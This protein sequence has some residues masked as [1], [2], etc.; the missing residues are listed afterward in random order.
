LT[1]TAIRETTL[2]D[3]VARRLVHLQW[4]ELMVRYREA[5]PEDEGDSIP[6]GDF[7]PPAGT[8]LVLE[9]DGEPVGC[10]GV[11]PC[12]EDVPG[13]G[14]IKR[15][16]VVE[17]CRGRGLSRVLLAALED[18]AA[19]LGYARIWLE[20]GTA[21]PEALAL[22]ASA[23]YAPIAPYGEYRDAPDVRCFQKLLPS[24]AS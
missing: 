22:Y 2:A 1:T 11:R 7:T 15:M 13:T 14:E 21:Q 8:F 3:P 16:Y 17:A 23:G 6:S 18:A 12:Q 19:R 20:T 24:L 5:P 9:E 4:R 10:G